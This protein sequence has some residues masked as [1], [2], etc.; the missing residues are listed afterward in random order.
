MIVPH[1]IA[2]FVA[3]V[4]PILAPLV[5]VLNP[6]GTIA[7]NGAVADSRPVSDSR[8]VGDSRPVRNAGPLA[9]TGPLTDARAFARQC[10]G[11][12]TFASQKF[13]GRA[14]CRATGDSSC[15]V[16]W[17][18]SR[19]CTRSTGAGR[20]AQVQKILQLPGGRSSG[21]ACAW[22]SPRAW[23]RAR[24]R[25]RPGPRSCAGDRLRGPR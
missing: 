7:G 13:R 4:R 14:P 2:D 21:D 6:I 20:R 25:T 16:S 10:T 9:D 15:Q 12:G 19:T 18:R 3:A 11:A 22:T 23:P 1:L 5:A 17:P 24:A 8:S